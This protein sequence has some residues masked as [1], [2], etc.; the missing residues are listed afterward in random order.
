MPI[1]NEPVMPSE[2]ALVLRDRFVAWL[3]SAHPELGISAETTW[4]R[5]PAGAE[6][7][8]V[9]HELFFSEE[10]ELGLSWHVM[11]APDDWAEMYLR[12]RGDEL[13]PSFGAR[14]ASVVGGDHPVEVPAPEVV[15]R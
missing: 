7:L 10:W 12:H 5:V 13:A 9:E 3:A 4:R 14:I 8:V 2:D 6:I 1:W 15:Q 11:I